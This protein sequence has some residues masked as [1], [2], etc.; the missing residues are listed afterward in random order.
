MR[1]LRVSRGFTLI[2][3]ITMIV[4]V[5]ILAVIGTQFIVRSAESYDI[6]QKRAL[7]VNTGRQALERMS[8]ELR[9]ALP[10]S[11][12]R[13]ASGAGECI[14]FMPIA[15]E[16]HYRNP[17]VAGVSQS[18]VNTTFYRVEVHQARYAALAALDYTE[19]N[20]GALS[21]L[22]ALG[23]VIAPPSSGSGSLALAGGH[24]WRRNSANQRFY[25]LDNPR[26]FCLLGGELRY[27]NNV[28]IAEETV[29]PSGGSTL[30][31]HHVTAEGV[32]F[33]VGLDT[34]TNR[35][36]VTLSMR[37][38]RRNESVALKQEV[39]LRNVP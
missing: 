16:G 35:S 37:F 25:L 21:S 32:G 7:L 36:L 9:G 1:A 17:I 14:K 3:L 27:F 30:M 5:G 20:L 23:S 29:P 34:V 18:E 6:T 28:G 10:Y 33:S 39:A 8:R 22:A 11:A 15:G 4:I 13:L 38:F 26:A 24:Q 31:A 2:E 19:L 12:K